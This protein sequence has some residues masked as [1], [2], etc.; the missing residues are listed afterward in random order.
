MQ[1]LKKIASWLIKLG[2]DMYQVGGSVRDEIMELPI[3]DIDICLV[4]GVSAAEIGHYLDMLAFAPNN[5]I[6]K[7]TSVHGDF[8]IWIVEIDGEKYEFA[9]A[10][11]ERKVGQ[12]HQDFLTEVAHVTIEEDLYRRDLTINA[13]A[14]NILTD[15]IVDPYLGVEDIKRRIAKPVSQAFREDPLRVIRAARF[16]ARFNLL[17]SSSLLEICE[18]L[19]PEGISAERV[20]IELMKMLKTAEKPSKFFYFLK[21]VNW[22]NPWFKELYDCIGVPQSPKHHPEGD[23]YTHTMYCLDAVPQGDWFMR[24]V[25]LCHDLGKAIKTT[26]DGAS[27]EISEIQSLFH[28]NPMNREWKIIS[29]GHEE[30]GV[31]ITRNMLQRISFAGHNTIRKIACLVELHMLRGHLIGRNYDKMLRR[32][33]RKL[34]HHK[35]R[36]IDL[37][38]TTFYDLSGRPPKPVVSIGE[39]YTSMYVSYA[40]ELNKSG[41]MEPIVTGEELLVLGVKEGPEM[42]KIIKHALEL[43]DRGTL[44]K[45][46]WKAIMKGAGYQSLKNI[47]TNDI[48]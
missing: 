22:L 19:K 35:L 1:K 6:D 27:W 10:R 42:G 31:E 2:I 3:E 5:I 14:K 23:V 44:K 38:M 30:A 25:M 33:L 29:A 39:L 17:V 8:P 13:I 9:M 37:V 11:K 15:E 32:T 45:H 4:G 34:R 21:E 18:F 48:L 26:I 40:D 47:N 36:Y 24:A 43:Q 41:E 20:G 46:N 7:V 28:K 16:I 12:S